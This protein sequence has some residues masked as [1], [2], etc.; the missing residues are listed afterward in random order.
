MKLF[1]ASSVTLEV[2][3]L[4]SFGNIEGT[5]G[6]QSFLSISIA[7]NHVDCPKPSSLSPQVFTY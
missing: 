4:M 6:L 1:A 2:S 3:L 5:R 7:I